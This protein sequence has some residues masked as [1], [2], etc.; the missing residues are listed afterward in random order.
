MSWVSLNITAVATS[1][2][3]N[4][5][6]KLYIA[7]KEAL[8]IYKL[9]ADIFKNRSDGRTT[10]LRSDSALS[11]KLFSNDYIN[12]HKKYIDITY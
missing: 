6:I 4:K 1:T 8:G 9:V 5:C 3:E 2:S 12:S 10:L 11:I 7:C